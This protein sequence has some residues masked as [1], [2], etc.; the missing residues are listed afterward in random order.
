MGVEI[1]IFCILVI[2]CI[3]GPIATTIEGD[4]GI[5]IG[6]LYRFNNIRDLGLDDFIGL[7]IM[8][9]IVIIVTLLY[10]MIRITTKF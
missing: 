6:N 2:W 3:T 4:W 8:G 1:L 7:F 5:M 9:P 10:M